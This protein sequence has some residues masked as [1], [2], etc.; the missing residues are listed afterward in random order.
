M[1]YLKP[2]L[3]YNLPPPTHALH[4]KLPRTCQAVLRAVRPGRPAV[5]ARQAAR[6]QDPDREGSVRHEGPVQ[7]RPGAEP[8]GQPVHQRQLAPLP[9]RADAGI[10]AEPVR[11]VQEY[12][13]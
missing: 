3:T 13:Q 4:R 9:G 12:C 1:Q 5:H 8:G 2:H 11:D 7:R 10:G 6:R